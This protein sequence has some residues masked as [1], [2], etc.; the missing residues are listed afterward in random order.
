MADN[1]NTIDI[2]LKVSDD[3]S[4]VLDKFSGKLTQVGDTAKDS[5]GKVQSS[6]NVIKLDSLINLG[7]RAYHAGRQLYEFGRETASI[8]ND[9]DRLS[10]VAGIS[11]ESFQKLQYAAKMTDVDTEALSMGIRKLSVNLQENAKLFDEV[12]INTKDA[13]GQLKPLDVLL[14]DIAEKFSKWEDGPEKIA[15]AVDM[16]GRSGERLIPML[17]KGK[18]GLEEFYQEV[19]K[20]GIVLDESLIKKGSQAE[21]ELKKIEAR[22]KTLKLEISVP[23]LDPLIKGLTNLADIAKTAYGWLQKIPGYG[24]HWTM[25]GGF[26]GPR[27]RAELE[28]ARQSEAMRGAE[29]GE[30]GG[31]ERLSSIRRNAEAAKALADALAKAAAEEAKLNA[32]FADDAELLK[33]AG[34]E[35]ERRNQALGLLSGMGVKTEMGAKADIEKVMDEFKLL[36]SMG[37]KPGELEAVKAQYMKQLD[38]IKAKYSSFSGWMEEEFEEGR[39]KWIHSVPKDELTASVEQMVNSAIQDLD[40][41]QKQIDQ[42]TKQ[43]NTISIDD[44]QVLGAANAIDILRQKL[45]T[46]TSQPWPV[47]ISIIGKGSSELP[48]MEKIDQIWNAFQT[49]GSGV[50][51]MVLQMNLSS[52]RSQMEEIKNKLYET[53]QGPG[54]TYSWN[55]AY[56]QSNWEQ[57][58]TSWANQLAALQQQAGILSSTDFGAGGD[59]GGAGGGG[60]ISINIGVIN[61]GGGGGTVAESLDEELASLW[62]KNRSKLK[63]VIQS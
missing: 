63:R 43:P 21:D 25:S 30:T 19:E 53:A 34:R 4:I 59:Y 56:M 24:S 39:V 49:M 11:T 61:I 20:L 41:M 10:K 18:K 2:K 52:I 12:G 13:S 5:L 35:V 42:M 36:A 32:Y 3:G 7:E 8:L 38:E 44:T 50:G 15:L 27:Q 6:L 23:I 14:G 48:I 22:L 29:L 9:I 58:R 28:A 1:S 26:K 45:E 37:L 31:K 55:A 51:Q 16:F 57:S 47:V 62:E 17:N 40:R 54:V 33:Q 46:L 60:G